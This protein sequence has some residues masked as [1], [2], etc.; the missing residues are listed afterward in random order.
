MEFKELGDV[1]WIE[2]PEVQCSTTIFC[3]ESEVMLSIAARES[4]GLFDREHSLGY[5]LHES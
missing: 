2:Q 1:T 5:M 3:V 4:L